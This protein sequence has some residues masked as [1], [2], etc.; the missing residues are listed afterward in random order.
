MGLFGD[1]KA[2]DERLD[3]LEHHVRV[4]TETVQANQADLAA[5]WIAILAL[6]AQVDE[7]VSASDVDP[8]IDALNKQL[9]NARTE[10][11]KAEARAHILEGYLKALD[12]IDE[13]IKLIRASSN[14]DEARKGLIDRFEFTEK[15]ANAVLDLK[16]YQITSLERDK[17]QNEYD[18]LLKKIAHLRAILASEQMVKDIPQKPDIG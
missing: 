15:Q 6:Q 2:Q 7:K 12:H 17:V 1:D 5:G 3:A 14:R 13:V 8:T 10:L 4:L 9:R 18:E 16:L 11:N